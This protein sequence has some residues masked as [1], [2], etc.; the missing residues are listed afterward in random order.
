MNLRILIQWIEIIRMYPNTT[1]RIPAHPNASKQ[2]WKRPTTSENIQFLS[3]F[4]LL[5][6]LSLRWH[7]KLMQQHKHFR[8]IPKTSKCVW[9]H[10]NASACIPA[11]PSA[12]QSFQELAKILKRLSKIGTSR[13]QVDRNPF[14]DAVKRFLHGSVVIGT[15]SWVQ[16]DVLVTW[17]AAKRQYRDTAVWQKFFQVEA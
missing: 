17:R 13:K 1:E 15:S 10:L 2:V 5:F 7:S 12:S 9:Q 16:M 11:H 14:Q 6:K 3:F 4:S 8:N